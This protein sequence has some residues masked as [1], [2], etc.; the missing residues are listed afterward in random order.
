MEGSK[1]L[2]EQILIPDRQTFTESFY[3]VSFY[4]L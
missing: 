3:Y 1:S 2:M 4:F